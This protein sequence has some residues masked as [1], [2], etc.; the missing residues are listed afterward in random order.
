MITVRFYA[1]LRQIAGSKEE[2]IDSDELSVRD[3]INSLSVK[4]GDEFRK[5]MFENGKLRGNVIILVNGLNVI[6]RDGLNEKVKS[7]DSVDMFPPVA[8]G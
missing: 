3:I 8:G 1:N 2:T 5:L 4:F 7:G 6:F